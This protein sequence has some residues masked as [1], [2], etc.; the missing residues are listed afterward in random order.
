MNKKELLRKSIHFSG[1]LYI[2]FYETFGVEI[3]SISL[4]IL[5]FFFAFFEFI[6]LKRGFLRSV[7][8]DYEQR[9]IGAY[10]YFL[11]ALTITTP[12]FPREAVFIAVS[13]TIIGDGLAGIV[14]GFGRDRIA[15]V[16]MFL[17]SISVAHFLGLLDLFSLSAIFTATLV[18]RV[19][20]LGNLRLEDNFTV[21]IVA[22]IV[23]SV[24]YISHV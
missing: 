16:A 17:S 6:R 21:P 20:N 24:K 23:C 3:V 5:T 8:R 11:L 13:T 15:S 14:R 2:P 22:T 4:I 10:F 18:E 1:I 7:F 9:R 12:F 19:K